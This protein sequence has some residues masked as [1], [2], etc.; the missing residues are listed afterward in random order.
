MRQAAAYVQQRDDVD[1][2]DISAMAAAG[3]IVFGDGYLTLCLYRCLQ[4]CRQAKPRND[5]DSCLFAVAKRC[6][7]IS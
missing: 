1:D 2:D 7:F 6:N 5:N 4:T 3:N